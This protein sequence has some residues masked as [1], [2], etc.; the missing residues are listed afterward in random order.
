MHSTHSPILLTCRENGPWLN[1]FVR[2]RLC[3]ALAHYLVGV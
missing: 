2:A 1:E 3:V